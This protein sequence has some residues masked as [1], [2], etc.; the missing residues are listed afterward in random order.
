M[1][2][3]LIEEEE[4]RKKKKASSG[5]KKKEKNSL[6]MSEAFAGAEN[7]DAVGRES[8]KRERQQSSIAEHPIV[9]QSPAESN[10]FSTNQDM[11]TNSAPDAPASST[12]KINKEQGSSTFE[13]E[14]EEEINSRKKKK[15]K[16]IGFSSDD[17]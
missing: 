10:Q 14:D 3:K 16:I 1:Q 5:R 15:R 7:L 17:E 2:M 8:R 9:I 13:K 6:D 11:N 4:K 12:T